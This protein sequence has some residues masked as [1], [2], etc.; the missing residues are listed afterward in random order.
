MR[1]K[2]ARLNWYM[3]LMLARSATTKYRM[4]PRVAAGRYCSRA[5]LMDV[6]VSSASRTRFCST[7]SQHDDGEAGLQLKPLLLILLA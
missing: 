2:Y 4:E 6:S 3:A 5:A 1:A 7:H